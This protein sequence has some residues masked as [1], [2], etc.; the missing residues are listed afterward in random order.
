MKT[1]RRNIKY[2]K[3]HKGGGGTMSSTIN[4]E[5]ENDTRIFYIVN[6]EEDTVEDVTNS[7]DRW[8]ANWV[9][10]N[11]EG[12]IINDIRNMI[13][14]Y[15]STF[16]NLTQE[17]YGRRENDEFKQELIDFLTAWKRGRELRMILN[18]ILEEESVEASLE[19]NIRGR[20][21]SSSENED[22][23]IELPEARPA[24]R[25]TIA[26]ASSR[27]DTFDP[28]NRADNTPLRQ[29]ERLTRPLPRVALNEDQVTEQ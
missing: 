6:L 2:N 10:D 14:T 20:I 7:Y 11:S 3:T 12:L 17:P 22:N 29:F 27:S 16:D 25:R 9:F 24:P 28:M 21:V 13:R 8:R 19:L 18:K 26:I 23:E 1:K 5:A 4:N 15:D